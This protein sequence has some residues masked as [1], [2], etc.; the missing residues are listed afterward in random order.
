MHT[1]LRLS[2]AV[3]FLWAGHLQA[4]TPLLPLPPQNPDAAVKLPPLNAKDTYAPS[5]D[6]APAGPRG[7]S[8]N[9][10][11]DKSLIFPGTET[12]VGVHI[13]AQYHPD[14]P[15][16]LYIIFDTWDWMQ[17]RTIIDNLIHKGEMPVTIIVS[18]N[19]GQV[20]KD[21]KDAKP[22]RQ[23]RLN[24]SYSYTTVNDNMARF[25]LE[26]V[27]LE[28]ERRKTPDGQPINISKNPNDRAIGGVSSGACNAF[29][30]A[31]ER[32]D[33]FS[34][35]FCSIGSWAINGGEKYPILIRKT[36]PKKLR[37][38]LE[39]GT[40]ST[41]DSMFGIWLWT[42]Q[43]MESALSFA[44][45]EV[46]HVW[47]EH[48][49]GSY[50]AKVVL[51]D[52]YRW[53]WKDWP[54]PVKAGTSQNA[55]L[56][57]I[58]VPNEEW[59]ELQL[60]ANQVPGVL[61]PHPQGGF[62]FTDTVAR[63]VCYIDKLDEPYIRVFLRNV[64]AISGMAFGADGTLYTVQPE[65][66]KVIAYDTSGAPKTIATGI[67]GKDITISNDG[68]IY[69]TE[70]DKIWL[71]KPGAKPVI[72]DTGILAVSGVAISPDKGRLVAAE[73]SSR[74]VF[75]FVLQPDGTLTHKA[76]YY[77]L[78]ITDIPSN[79]GAQEVCYDKKGNLYVATRLG[80]QVCDRMGRVCAILP[81][82]P[83]HGSAKSLCFA[84]RNFETMVATDGQHIFLRK[85]GLAGYSQWA[86]P[87]VLQPENNPWETD[88]L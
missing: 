47:G 13:P 24:R 63:T 51:G 49:H 30:V 79:A 83:V 81:L 68:M 26:E 86:T 58:L 75:D 78:H 65:E 38:F 19:G 80:I 5:P 29:T 67:R 2:L 44:G 7:K 71:I 11:W 34:R 17:D 57:K 53:L 50:L 61:A 40:N 21:P 64:P 18:I 60:G 87:F 62:Y 77:W 82:P 54:N 28:V 25:I 73:S 4:F 22:R 66:R 56:Q 3:A 8:F 15:A 48:G 16:C 46:E 41:W 52:I 84:G 55:M 14:K 10:T 32:P 76:R 59:R 27:L 70:P 69:V 45:Y 43:N 72:V 20:F 42:N 35:V 36:E 6:Q 85:L 9:F 88:N 1:L 31:W 37:V 39:D 23:A 33:A 74:S 12:N